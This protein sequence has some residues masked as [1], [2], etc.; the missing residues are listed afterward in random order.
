MGV[1]STLEKGNV[2]LG[3][4][5]DGQ[6][7]VSYSDVNL[8]GENPFVCGFDDLAENQAALDNISF[9]PAEAMFAPETTNCVR[10]YYELTRSI[11][12]SRGRD[13]TNTLNWITRSEERRVGKE[14][15]CRWSPY[16]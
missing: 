1:I 10:I 7:Y 5:T 2:V 12:N 8:M 15:R 3:K 9:D 16:D 14:C 11:W 6:D 4:S 13:F